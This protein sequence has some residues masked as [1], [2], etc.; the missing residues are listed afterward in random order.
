MERLVER[1]VKSVVA[2]MMM[3]AVSC[4]ATGAH[5]DT[6]ALQGKKVA[7]MPV[8]LGLDLTD[9]WNAMIR[10][11]LAPLGVTFET[12]D[13]NWSTD[14]GA[15]AITS[16]ISEKPDIMLI[17]NPDV[18]SYGKLLKRAES[19]GIP[20]IQ[21]NL[22]SATPTTAFVG[23]DFVGIG[24]AMA[25]AVISKCG[26]GTGKSGK[27]GIVQGVLT[28]SASVDQMKG[29]ESVFSKHPE[30]KVVSNQAADW[31]SSKAR[32]ITDTVI[33]QNPD[34][35][36]IIGFWDG[37]DAGIGAAVKEAGKQGQ[38]LVVTNGGA[39]SSACN[40]VKNGAFSVYKAYDVRTQSNTVVKIIKEI[41]EKGIKPGTATFQ[42]KTPIG[43]IDGA[44]LTDG[45]CWSIADYK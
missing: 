2:G 44:S 28:A 45:S 26:A 39:A 4:L 11:Q 16:L 12:R 22:L 33:Q 6:N 30:I 43:T 19:A 25:D 42:E 10:K 35:C 5:A 17:Q 8:A 41:L 3:S 34:L 24:A 38:I 37:Q 21:L 1:T 29:V 36:A 13:P 14:A 20:V 23:A 40:N 9:G 31:N 7:Y 27:V 18:A 15:Q 32:A